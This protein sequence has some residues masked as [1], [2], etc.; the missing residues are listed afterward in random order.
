MLID[1]YDFIL[2]IVSLSRLN[3]MKRYCFL[4]LV[5]F[6]LTVVFSIQLSARELTSQAKTD[7]TGQRRIDSIN[8]LAL[9]IFLANPIKAQKLAQ[10]ALLEAKKI[11]YELGIG[12][13]MINIGKAYWAQSY[14]P[15]SFFYYNGA[16]KYLQAP[17]GR[18]LLSDCYRCMARNY[19]DLKKYDQAFTF[20]QQALASAGNNLLQQELA[21]TERSLAYFK[22]KQYDKS[23][24][25]ASAAMK[26]CR[27]IHNNVSLAV[28]YSRLYGV[29]IEKKE[30]D[31]ALA[32][33]DTAFKLG[34][35]SHNN[36]LK[37]TCLL[38]MANIAGMQNR[39]S[40]AVEL[41]LKA[42]AFADSVGNLQ[43]YSDA[44]KFLYQVYNQG[45]DKDKALFYQNKYIALQD[46]LNKLDKQ[47]SIQ[48]VEDYFS[49][50]T[51]LHDIEEVT[52]KN[53]VNKVLIKSQRVTIYN[54]AAIILVLSIAMYLL[55]R[56]Y[57]QRNELSE[58]LEARHAEAVEQHRVIQQQS[59]NLN[60]LNQQKDRLL[61]IIGHD[62]KTPLANISGIVD[63][64]GSGDISAQEAQELMIAVDPVIKGAELTLSSLVEW[65][66]SQVKGNRLN[67]TA[68]NLLSV[69]DEL[70]N[71]YTYSLKKKN[72]SLSIEINEHSN[73]LADENH[74]KMILRN[75]V[76]NAIKFTGDGGVVTITAQ[77]LSG[78]DK[79][80]ISVID[81]GKGMSKEE[82]ANL[83]SAQTHFSQPGTKGEKGSGIGLLLCRQLV[84]INGGEI[85]VTSVP[86]KG[87]TFYF[88]L[89]GIAPILG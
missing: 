29:Y 76:S 79:I 9:K 72:I 89:I 75:L 21:V 17:Q 46:S 26:I 54:L 64:F 47:N 20:L 50:N 70:R 39:R 5:F 19:I 36:R 3:L 81:T 77:Q 34:I 23:I 53:E 30:F 25:D 63:L 49:L 88:T 10:N 2:I 41:A 66:G 8:N 55:Y 31:K 4:L 7:T 74:F 35:A 6:A 43:V 32:Y 40:S 73:V 15:V 62:L 68:V 80:M 65:A 38:S 58:Q 61:A 87:S 44:S 33:C 60:E 51:K 85:A 57:R 48:L 28:G 56:Y 1:G 83:F 52:Q 11:G 78:S 18:L 12:A 14:Y 24:T 67:V 84:E 71:I 42:S 16:L 27:K 86:G 59:A 69:A 13:S 82:L 37:A 45:G 22:L